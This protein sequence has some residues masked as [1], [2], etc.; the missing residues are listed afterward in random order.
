MKSVE[1]K[2]NEY[3]QAIKEYDVFDIS[4][5][6]APYYEE[7]FKKYNDEDKL[8]EDHKNY[9]ING[10]MLTA[11]YAAFND[12]KLGTE[13]AIDL[14]KNRENYYASCVIAP[15]QFYVPEEGYDYLKEAK[16]KKVIAARIYPERFYFSTKEYTIGSMC[17]VLESLDMPLILWHIDTG[18][19]SIDEICSNHPK[20][21][22]IIDSMDR[23]LLY[24]QRDYISLM[25][26]HENLFIEN[27]N[28]VLFNEY[29]VID[30]YCGPYHLMYGSF[31]PYMDPDF[32]LYP[33]YASGLTEEKKQLIYSGNAKRVFNIN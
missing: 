11:R 19:D 28:L 25:K 2:S 30:K 26:K 18:W 20:L 9:E 23:K 12:Y 29:D 7:T 6:W 10:G 13:D 1:E 4:L 33:I 17:E 16:K 21:K 32:S 27:H 14:V 3:K 8:F 24:H 5:W 15:E 22:V 31:F